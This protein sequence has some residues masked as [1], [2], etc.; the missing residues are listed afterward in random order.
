MKK[1]A[2][3][4][5]AMALAI[6]MIFSI[7]ACGESGGK[8]AKTGKM[9]LNEYISRKGTTIIYMNDEDSGGENG[10]DQPKFPSKDDTPLYILVFNGGKVTVMT[11]EL[12]WGDISKM[13]DEE[14]INKSTVF[15]EQQDCEYRVVVYSDDSGNETKVE[16]IAIKYNNEI[17]EWTVNNST[18]IGSFWYITGFYNYPVE[19]YDC[20]FTGIYTRDANSKDF[21]GENCSLRTLW[22]K[23]PED[24]EITLSFDTPK[25]KEVI[26]DPE[27]EIRGGGDSDNSYIP[28]I[29]I[30]S[31]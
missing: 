25:S 28:T 2:K 11:T 29:D 30:F 5:M 20:E 3:K 15:E 4:L 13:S 14:I 12:T 6:V 31:E 24:G 7:S 16:T 17:P 1:I 10:Y 19:V 21:T 26:V 27:I 8:A 18:S 9:T 23:Q 22:I